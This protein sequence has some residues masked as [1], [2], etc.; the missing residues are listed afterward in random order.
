MVIMIEVN[1][2]VMSSSVLCLMMSRAMP[3]GHTHVL[4]LLTSHYRLFWKL[5]IVPWSSKASLAR[6]T[7][8]I[9]MISAPD[10][11]TPDFCFP[12]FPS[13]GFVWTAAH[14]KKESS[15]GKHT[16]ESRDTPDSGGTCG[17]ASPVGM[18]SSKM[19][20]TETL[21]LRQLWN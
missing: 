1:E 15:H 6:W 9:P 10:V 3:G 7:I 20:V 14:F 5:S 11:L 19:G 16:T 2:V 17:G 4:V 18:R 13:S 21:R 12:G 8:P